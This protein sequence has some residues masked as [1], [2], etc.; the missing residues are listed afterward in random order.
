MNRLNC[1]GLSGFGARLRGMGAA[2]TEARHQSN[3]GNSSCTASVS[4]ARQRRSHGPS[5]RRRIERDLATSCFVRQ[6]LALSADERVIRASLIVNAELLPVVVAEIELGKIAVKM[7]FFNV[8]VDADQT[9]LE[10]REEA[11]ERVGMGVAAHVFALGVI[12]EFV[13]TGGHDGWVPGPPSRAEWFFYG[14]AAGVL[15]VAVAGA[16]AI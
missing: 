3:S 6:P 13:L 15:L 2:Y 5:E 12:D 7:L 16:L 8:L 4:A 14:F 11:F 10:H 9:A 1:S